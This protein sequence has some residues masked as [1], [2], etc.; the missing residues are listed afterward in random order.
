MRKS[1]RGAHFA[2]P[3]NSRLDIFLQFYGLNIRASRAGDIGTLYGFARPNTID[4]N[5]LIAHG[6]K[7][8]RN[9]S[10]RRS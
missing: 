1:E 3:T 4:R 7:R 5:K 8:Q 2:W 6:G 9:E 10:E